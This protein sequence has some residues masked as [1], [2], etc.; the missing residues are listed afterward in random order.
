MPAEVDLVVEDGTGLTTANAYVTRAYCTTYHELRSN[1]LWAESSESDQVSAIILATDYL[2][3]RWTFIGE[4][5]TA[6]QALAWPR[7]NAIGADRILYEDVVPEAVKRACAEYALRVLGDG[8][9]LALL[10][11][12]PLTDA[13]GAFVTLKREKLGPLEEETR[14]SANSPRSSLKPYPAADRLLKAA[15]LVVSAQRT[16]RA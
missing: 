11:P 5:L 16:I 15:G 3:Y 13:T 2:D 6:E 14:F 1:A 12:D 4:K 8:A 7:S 9:A 10:A